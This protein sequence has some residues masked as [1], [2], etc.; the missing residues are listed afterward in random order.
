MFCLYQHPSVVCVPGSI[1]KIEALATTEAQETAKLI[2]CMM[3]RKCDSYY[4][5][6]ES[7]RVKTFYNSQCILTWGK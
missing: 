7:P 1:K 6:K 4:G 5:E 3:S 2:I